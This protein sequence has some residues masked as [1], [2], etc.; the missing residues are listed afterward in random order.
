[1]Y[2]P[3]EWDLL[4]STGPWTNEQVW[5]I[6]SNGFKP[7]AAQTDSA[8]IADLKSGMKSE[9]NAEEGF[10]TDGSHYLFSTL[11]PAAPPA[12]NLHLVAM[13]HNVLAAVV[14]AAILAIGIVLTFTRAAVRLIAIGAGLVLVVLTGVFLP[15]LAHQMANG[16]TM[17]AGFVVLVIWALWYILWTRPRDPQIVAW[18]QAREAARRSLA[19]MV[20]PRP[21]APPAEKKEKDKGGEPHA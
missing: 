8:L 3:P 13:R 11:R 1:V 7:R 2:L 4:G 10:P 14:F 9:G 17:A 20:S 16:V 15:T 19:E 18:R 6:H 12:G 21:A 5:V